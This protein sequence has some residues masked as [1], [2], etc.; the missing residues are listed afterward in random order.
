MLIV[1]GIGTTSGPILGTLV[2]VAL[3]ELLRVAKLY[4]L[5]LLGL[6]IVVTVLFV[7]KGLAGLFGRLVA[8]RPRRGD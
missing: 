2:F 5:V 4:R 3:P 8:A 7:P 1:G 6:I